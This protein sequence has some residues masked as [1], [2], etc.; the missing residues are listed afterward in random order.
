M[1]DFFQSIIDSSKDRIKSPFIGAYIT[2]FLIYNWRP[3]SI[4]L[5]SSKTLECKIEEIDEKYCLASSLLWPL[6]IALFYVL[7]LPF[8]NMIFEAFLL[9]P[10][11]QRIKQKH[12]KKIFELNTKKEEYRIEKELEDIRAGLLDMVNLNNQIQQLQNE[13]DRLQEQHSTTIL[14]FENEIKEMQE[15]NNQIS[16]DFQLL[17]YESRDGINGVKERGKRVFEYFSKDELREFI[18]ICNDYIFKSNPDF[19]QIVYNKI[20]ESYVKRGFFKKEVIDKHNR[21]F[22]T[23][24]G[25]EIY[26]LSFIQ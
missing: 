11:Q 1:K 3:I 9:Y 22:L 23:D 2:S 18:K 19:S 10:T 4:Y 15:Q 26:N 20:L 17:K 25:L 21:Y 16:K 8:I 12:N 13:K 14:N 24:L 6:M 5:F 7:F